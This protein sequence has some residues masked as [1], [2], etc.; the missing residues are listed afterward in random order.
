MSATATITPELIDDPLLDDPA[1]LEADMRAVQHFVET[2]QPLD[3]EVRDR[4]IARADLIRE[5][6]FQTHGFVDGEQ[7]RAPST[8]DE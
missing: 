3:P 7:F 5:Q 6:I 4:V 8:Y 1:T 2:R